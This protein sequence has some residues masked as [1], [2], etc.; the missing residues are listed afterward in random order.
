MLLR[1]SDGFQPVRKIGGTSKRVY[2]LT[3]S[4]F[5]GG[6]DES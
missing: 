3:T 5:A 2:V 6:G 4:I 1:A